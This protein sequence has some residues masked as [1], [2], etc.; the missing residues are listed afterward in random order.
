MDTT[1]RLF[2]ANQRKFLVLRDQACRTPW[3][4]AP[5]RHADHITG[6]ANGGATSTASGQ[7]LCEACNHTKQAPGW[8]QQAVP[9]G[10][11]LTTTPTGHQYLSRQPH[12]PGW[13]PPRTRIDIS[14]HTALHTAA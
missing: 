14:F 4:D 9:G 12:P 1:A 3:C 13:R 10:G 8:T 2:T 11:V 7:G 6:H 5:V